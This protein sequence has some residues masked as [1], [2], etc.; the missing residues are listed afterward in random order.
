STTC[1]P[2]HHTATAPP[3]S[4]RSVKL[5]RNSSATR[6]KRGSQVPD[7]GAVMAELYRVHAACGQFPYKP[8][9]WFLPFVSRHC[10][11]REPGEGH[12]AEQSGKRRRSGSRR[13]ARGDF[14]GCP[15]GCEP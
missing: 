2:S 14:V 1:L 10:H 6:E 3:R 8:N 9:N 7:V 13:G 15:H 5:R 11:S 12:R 4:A